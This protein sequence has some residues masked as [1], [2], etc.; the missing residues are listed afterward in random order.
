MYKENLIKKG[1]VFLILFTGLCLA[2][3]GYGASKKATEK[4]R[5]LVVSS[6]HRAY[7][8]SQET[9]EGFCEAL[10]KYGYLDDKSQI[11]EYTRHDYVES[12]RAVIKKL[13]MD[14]KRKGSKEEMA[15]ATSKITQIAK[16]FKPDLIFL[17]DD[18]AAGYI[19][20][21]FLDTEIP[22]VFWGVNKTPVKYGLV[23]SLDRPGHNVTGVVQTGYY[24]E[25]LKLLKAIV[26]GVKT[27]AILNDQT[28][29][30]RAHYKAIE[31]LVRKGTIPLKLIERISTDRYDV[32]KRKAMELQKKV[33]A[34]FIT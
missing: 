5:L 28:S 12:S 24:A 19:G 27:F 3:V 4:K 22:V 9:N 25:S 21:Q 2:S 8:W 15:G 32:W 7:P 1:G 6:Y 26:P 20:N 14:T 11:V 16:N 10:L 33:D 13:W 29:S 30:G 23:D 18:N 31:H 34:F 17:G